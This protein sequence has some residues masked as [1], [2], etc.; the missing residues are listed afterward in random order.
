MIKAFSLAGSLINQMILRLM[1]ARM[2]LHPQVR[3][4]AVLYKSLEKRKMT[5]LKL[6]ID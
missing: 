5:Q 3:V 2:N 6:F 4:T 1:R